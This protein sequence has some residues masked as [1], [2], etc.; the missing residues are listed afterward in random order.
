M[1]WNFISKLVI[2]GPQWPVNGNGFQ[3]ILHFQLDNNGNVSG[4]VYGDSLSNIIIEN[5][6]IQF[7]RNGNGFHQI[8]TGAIVD[9]QFGQ[10]G[11]DHGVVLMGTFTHDDQGC[12]GWTTEPL[13]LAV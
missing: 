13:V 5:N 6:F 4:T 1:A 3:G 10:G 12:F 7:R 2:S 11:I 9:L 8:W